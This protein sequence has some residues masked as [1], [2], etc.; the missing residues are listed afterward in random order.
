MVEVARSILF[1]SFLQ[2]I[3]NSEEERIFRKKHSSFD[4]D[5]VAE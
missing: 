1:N 4:I 3:N 2:K 5:L